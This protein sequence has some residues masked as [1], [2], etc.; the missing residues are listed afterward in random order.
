MRKFL[1]ATALAALTFSVMPAQATSHAVVISE[2]SA[3]DWG[4]A[5]DPE[6]A[7]LGSALGQDLVSASL[8]PDLEGGVMHFVIGVTE[9]PE[10]GGVPE[11]SRYTWNFT[12]G[13]K[14]TE[15]DGK[16]TNY[17]RGACD[18]TASTCPPPRDPGEAPFTLRGNCTVTQ[19]VT[20]CQE[21]AL[22]HA[23]FDP[24]TGTIDIPVPLPL[25]N[26]IASCGKIGVGTGLFGGFLSAMPAAFFTSSAMPNDVIE[27][28]RIVPEV[29]TC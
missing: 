7:P 20:L 8:V 15:L 21:L 4:V 18:P 22:L 3:G 5:V 25:L 27:Q 17:S 24:A 1:F 12:V 11:F 23:T 28:D 13:G 10:I 26:A 16:F 14:A 9:L 6:I 2:D 29:S 19:T